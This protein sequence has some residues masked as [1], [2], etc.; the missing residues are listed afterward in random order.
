MGGHR[1]K[2]SETNNESLFGRWVKVRVIQ[3]MMSP[4]DSPLW[5]V[6]SPA[7][8]GLF[9]PVLGIQKMELRQEVCPDDSKNTKLRSQECPYL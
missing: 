8:S 2:S 7:F 3:E 4:G 9:P 6:H 5:W 1:T